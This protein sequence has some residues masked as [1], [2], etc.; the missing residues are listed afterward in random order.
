[1]RIIRNGFHAASRRRWLV[2]AAVPAAVLAAL[3][4]VAGPVPLVGAG[5]GG[6]GGR[7]EGAAQTP[8]VDRG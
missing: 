3:G 8:V 2:V 4:V 1:M 5:S 7:A 6:G